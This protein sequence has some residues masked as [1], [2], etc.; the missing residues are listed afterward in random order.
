MKNIVYARVDDRLVHGQVMTAWVL[1]T[2]ASKVII[3]DDKAAKDSFMKMIMKS[4]MPSS[5]ELE[6]LSVSSAISKKQA[7]R[8]NVSFCSQKHRWFSRI[9]MMRVFRYRKWES[10]ESVPGQ[11]DESCIATLR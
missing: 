3:V 1:H 5:L 4:A 7:V 8:M 2:K 10:A 9:C 6:V 11:T